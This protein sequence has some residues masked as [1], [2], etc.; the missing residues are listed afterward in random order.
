MFS[1]VITG[2]K[3]VQQGS[4]KAIAVTRKVGGQRVPTGKINMLEMGK[5]HADWRHLVE[6]EAKAEMAR[7][8]GFVMM[9]GPLVL[10]GC[11]Y[12]PRP[13]S[14]SKTVLSY[15]MSTPDLSKLIR[16]VEDSLTTAGVWKDDA[17]VVSIIMDE[18]Y[19]IP[20]TLP[21]LRDQVETTYPTE[22]G[23]VLTVETLDEALR[24]GW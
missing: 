7:T 24:G 12:M 21:K 4:K 19:A 1:L 23:V 5:G 8:E 20:M 11:F 3:P 10:S 13:A 15:P 18:R 22:P 14:H 17:R 9:D 2:T 16:A 6:V